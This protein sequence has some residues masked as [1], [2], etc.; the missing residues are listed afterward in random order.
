L[1][2]RADVDEADAWRVRPNTTAAAYVRGDTREK[3]RL[4]FVRF[5]PYVLPKKSLTGDA[6]ERV[7]TR[8]LH[9][10][11]RIVE[12]KAPVYVGQQVDVR[13]PLTRCVC[14]CVR[15]VH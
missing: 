11:Y 8:V 2:I 3:L 9:A 1:N 4:Q 13:E 14:V 7:D 12:E 5:E 10:I 15:C 6:T